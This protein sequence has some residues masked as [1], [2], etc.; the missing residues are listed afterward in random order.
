MDATDRIREALEAG[1]GAAGLPGLVAAARPPGEAAV[2]VAVGQR[3]IDDAAPMTPDTHFWIASCTKALTATAALML[4]D[5]GLL[6]LDATVGELLPTL[7]APKL[8]KGFDAGGAPLLEP[9]GETVTLRRLLTH[10]SGY[11]YHFTDAGLLRALG[12]LGLRFDGAEGPDQPLVFEPGAGWVYGVGI[13]WTGKLC[14][15]VA[16]E[17]LDSFMRRRVFDP[18]GMRDT[19]FFPSDAQKARAA[20]MHGR[21]DDGGVETRPFATASGPNFMMGGGGLWS[22][23]PDYLKFIDFVL[24]RG[25]QLLS[26]PAMEGLRRPQVEGPAVG[27][28]RTAVPQLSNDFD[29]VPGARK[30]WTL[31]FATNLDP[32]PNGRRPGSLCWGGL[33]NCYYWIDPEAGAAG[34]LFAQMLPFADARVLEAF[35]AFE[36][37]VYRA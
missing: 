2:V 20:P 13:D 17:P 5:E 11:A 26:E 6:D 14:E 37:A 8:L 3:G 29:P 32:G 25:P 35:G 31:G 4:V 23:A 27:L 36:R 30:G 9:A 7:A 24:G 33:A 15:A 28:L 22:T 34:L 19:C 21:T 16:G 10:T 1:R 12:P 18:L